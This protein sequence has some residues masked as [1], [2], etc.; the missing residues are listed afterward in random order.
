MPPVEHSNHPSAMYAYG[1]RGEIAQPRKNH[2]LR[3]IFWTLL[4]LVIVFACT[5]AYFYLKTGVVQSEA[6]L[7]STSTDEEVLARVGEHILL[8]ESEKPTIATVSDIE[9]LR[10]QPFFTRAQEGDFV[11]IYPSGRLILY[12]P[13]L[14]RIVEAGVL[15]AQSTSNPQEMDL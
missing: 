8:P 4:L 12:R 7:G 6:G 2:R 10:D 15:D 14:E 1:A 5:T 9:K 11:L 3:I 13:S